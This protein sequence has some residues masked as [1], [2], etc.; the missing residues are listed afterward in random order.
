MTLYY[1]DDMVRLHHG[2]F[3]EVTEWLSADVLVF[4]PP[5][6]RDWKQ[7]L[8]EGHG[9]QR[10]GIE[11]DKDTSTRDRALAMWFGTQPLRCVVCFGDLMLAPPRGTKQVLVYAKGTNHGLRGA[12]GGFRRDA[13]AIYLIGPWPAGLGGDTSVLRTRSISGPHRG[14]SVRHGH[15]HA[16]PGDVMEPLIIHCPP[17]VIADPTCGSGGTLVAAR[18]LGRKAIGVEI[19]ERSCEKA[20]K[21]LQ[22]APISMFTAPAGEPGFT[23]GEIP[24]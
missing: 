17:G 9:N 8:L 15:P 11:G 24:F 6:G 10:D 13:E 5:Y 2:D 16:K 22:Q 21:R 1:E 12:M 4:D 3:R 23:Q 19:D 18:N 14:L 7:G 20:A